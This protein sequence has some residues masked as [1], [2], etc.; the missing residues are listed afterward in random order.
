MTPFIERFVASL[1][2]RCSEVGRTSES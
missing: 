2:E 1:L